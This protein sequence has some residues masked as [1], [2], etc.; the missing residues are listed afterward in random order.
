MLALSRIG[1]AW[2]SE[3]EKRKQTAAEIRHSS[4][5]LRRQAPRARGRTDRGQQ[6][7]LGC[8]Q[9]LWGVLRR[10]P[11]QEGAGAA[12]VW[13]R[14]KQDMKWVTELS[15]PGRALLHLFGF[16]QAKH[17]CLDTFNNCSPSHTHQC[18][19]FSLHTNPPLPPGS[20]CGWLVGKC[21]EFP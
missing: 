21:P 1:R 19:L 8:R 15:F 20:F 18:L 7:C 16:P 13:G 9:C 14:F 17:Y 2:W 5:G 12:M 4:W 10:Q 3:S 11:R 6:S